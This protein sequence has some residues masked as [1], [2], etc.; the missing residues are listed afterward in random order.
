[1]SPI[2]CLLASL[3]SHK[4]ATRTVSLSPLVQS[5]QSGGTEFPRTPVVECKTVVVPMVLSAQKQTAPSPIVVVVP[6]AGTALLVAHAALH[7]SRVSSRIVDWQVPQAVDCVWVAVWI[8]LDRVHEG[9]RVHLR[10]GV[11]AEVRE[12]VH[13]ALAVVGDVHDVLPVDVEGVGHLGRDVVRACLMGAIAHDVVYGKRV[14]HRV[15]VVCCLALV[16]VVFVNAAAA[17]F[18]MYEDP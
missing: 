14:H 17:G 13:D 11:V 6:M 7:L 4:T 15:Y 9:L 12:A 3:N 8:C 1:M 5:L 10:E 18:P 16:S 2:S